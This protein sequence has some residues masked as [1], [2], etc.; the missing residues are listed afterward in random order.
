MKRFKVNSGLALISSYDDDDDDDVDDDIKIE[1]NSK[2][3]PRL[4]DCSLEDP[5]FK[6]KN[7]SQKLP[8]PSSIVQLYKDVPD[9]DGAPE[10]N[11]GQHNGRIRSFP[12]QRGNWS[13]YVYVPYTEEEG[14]PMLLC[15]LQK[16]AA[17]SGVDLMTVPEPHVSLTRTV[18]L[19]HHWIDNFITSVR[20]KLGHL[21]RFSVQLGAPAVY[22]NEERTRTFLGLRALTGVT[23]LCTATCVL[24]E[25]L[26]EFRLPPFYKEPS[27]HMSVLWVVG[28][29]RATL[30]PLV[31]TLQA[32]FDA[33]M[34]DHPHELTLDVTQCLCKSGNK[35]FAFSL[36]SL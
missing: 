3:E 27:F 8:L 1:C 7:I 9:T 34:A 16:C 25:C 13:T 18:V 24:D 14:F 2:I 20:S 22:C 23:E 11:P 32:E 36:A 26:A 6:R 12:H 21:P 19:L 17:R 29:A 15:R 28:D 5:S 10:D 30:E 4:V 31:P 33:H 35:S